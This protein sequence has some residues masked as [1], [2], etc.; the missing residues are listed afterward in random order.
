[1][2]GLN[3]KLSEITLPVMQQTGSRLRQLLKQ[4]STQHQRLQ[5]VLLCDP[6]AAMAVFRELER[7]RPG[8]AEQ[9]SDI[10][11]ALSL[12]GLEGFRRLLDSLPEHP[13]GLADLAQTTGPALAYSQCAHAAAYAT[14]LA[15]HA[16]IQA[17]HEIATAALLQNPAMLALWAVEPD[18]A[19]RATYVMRDGVPVDIAFGT[20]LGEPL[21]DANRRLGEVWAFPRLARQAMD[22]WD[23]FNPRLQAIKLA[24]DLAQLGAAGWAHADET[25]V[26]APLAH[27]LGVDDDQATS[28]LHRCAVDNARELAPLG[29][30]LPGFELMFLPGERELDDDHEIPELGAWRKR[31]A[32]KQTPAMPDLHKAMSAIMR[33]IHKDTGATRIVFMML[34]PD[35]RRLR[36][37]LALGGV[38]DDPIRRLDLATKQRNL[39]TALLTKP[40]SLWLQTENLRKYR[41]YLTADLA[42]AV[43][44]R[45]SFMM[46]IFAHERALG[47]IYADGSRLNAEAYARFRQRCREAADTLSGGKR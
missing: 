22:D 39:F 29:Y 26:T 4:P 6:A 17:L 9:V 1:M 45:G 31:L 34:S 7:I 15:R 43:D 12:I 27:F 25:R 33:D 36:T 46:S 35:R 40:Q 8:S 10:A 13:R 37:R 2:T 41:P 21:A 18:S 38:A 11:H 24:D 30:P 5:Q 23:E 16:D 44:T 32:A 14:A 3:P 47:L 28:W 20:E 19:Q 42:A